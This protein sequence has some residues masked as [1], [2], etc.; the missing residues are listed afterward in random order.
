MAKNPLLGAALALMAGSAALFP[1][2]NAGPERR[3][4]IVIPKHKAKG[5][6]P[7]ENP[8]AE[9]RKMLKVRAMQARKANQRKGFK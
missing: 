3:S 7:P 4:P 2:F 9:R 1:M 5:P 6:P 8:K